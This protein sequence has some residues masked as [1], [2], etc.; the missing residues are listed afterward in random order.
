MEPLSNEETMIR[1]Y[2]LDLGSRMVPDSGW[3]R[4]NQLTEQ[5][6]LLTTSADGATKLYRD[7][8]DGRFWERTPVSPTLPQGPPVLSVIT[9]VLARAGYPQGFTS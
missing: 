8:V 4:I 7:P 5:M 3:E 2:W 6:E 1:G 9:E